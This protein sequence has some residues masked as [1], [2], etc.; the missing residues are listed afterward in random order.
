MGW[1]WGGNTPLKAPPPVSG[2]SITSHLQV[3]VTP[4]GSVVAQAENS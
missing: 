4:D 2:V 3:A 1:N